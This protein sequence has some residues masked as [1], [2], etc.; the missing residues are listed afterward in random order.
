MIVPDMGIINKS[1]SQLVPLN[2]TCHQLQLPT[3]TGHLAVLKTDRR[4]S[5]KAP[6]AT[7]SDCDVGVSIL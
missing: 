1:S 5:A 3:M 2:S 7:G 4:V 6:D